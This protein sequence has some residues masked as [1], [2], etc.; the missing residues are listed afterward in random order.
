[1]TQK[2]PRN[3]NLPQNRYLA[4][5]GYIVYSCIEIREGVQRISIGFEL[6]APPHVQIRGE[7]I[8]KSVAPLLVREICPPVFS[9]FHNKLFVVKVVTYSILDPHAAMA[10]YRSMALGRLTRWTMVISGAGPPTNIACKASSPHKIL[11]NRRCYSQ[12][13]S[14][15]SASPR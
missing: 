11:T 13:G 2:S 4:A 10:T 14:Q 6:G 12:R 3:L 8:V 15:A 7:I 9:T 1:M 5:R